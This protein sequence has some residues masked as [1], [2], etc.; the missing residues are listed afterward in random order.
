MEVESTRLSEHASTYLRYLFVGAVVGVLTI[1]L[2]ELFA[3]ML[4]ADTPAYYALSV[5]MAYAVG[6]ICS[7]YGHRNVTFSA[8][9]LV[10]GHV[11][12]FTRFSLIAIAGLLATTIM[13]MSIRYGLPVERLLGEYAGGSAFALATFLASVL[14]YS[15]NSTFTFKEQTDSSDHH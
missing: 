10:S 8:R 7:Y 4:P 11:G 1:L 2:R 3:F 12:A 15:L 9:E 14:T 13:S 5:V 6:I